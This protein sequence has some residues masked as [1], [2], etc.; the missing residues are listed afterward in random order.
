MYIDPM[1]VALNTPPR[2]KMP[3]C[4]DAE[5]RGQTTIFDI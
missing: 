2:A 4:P 1:S 3:L 5:K